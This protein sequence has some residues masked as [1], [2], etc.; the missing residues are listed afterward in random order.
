MPTPPRRLPLAALPTPLER[1][2]RL[3]AMWGGPRIWVK[4]DDL[5]GFGLTGNKVRKLE[6]HLAA[7]IDA[8]ADTVVTCG[9]AQSN[10]C[11]STAL[12]CARLGL[13]SVLLLRTPDGR[14][15]DRYTGNHL[16]DLLAGAQVRYVTPEEYAN[17][18]EVM[19]A[20]ADAL[21]AAGR[22]PWVVPEGASDALGMWGFVSAMIEIADQLAELTNPVGV[23]H[24]ASSGGTTAGLGW[25]ADR[26]GNE[27]PIIGA[28]IGDTV[29]ELTARIDTIW[30]EALTR[31]GGDWPTPTLEL[32]DDHV[33]RGYGLTTPD[34]LRT[35]REVTAATGL[36]LDPTYT[37]K[38]IHGLRVEIS[39]GRFGPDDDVV[40]WHTGGG[41]AV[42]AHPDIVQA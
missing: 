26:T 17:R 2:D 23:W 31:H 19:A 7:A 38:A 40:F 20:T 32:I 29:H 42:F 24:A 5:T 37:G 1:A 6:Y 16:L 28:S 8:G 21:A 25:A 13:R 10:H 12:A 35:Q 39:T 9:A 3:S 11:R 14:P 41:F 30:A 4:R 34:E 22:T 18:S 36:V 33:G 27:I 15:P